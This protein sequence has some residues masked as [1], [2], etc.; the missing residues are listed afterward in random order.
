VLPPL[1]L[2]ALAVAAAA[3][4]SEAPLASEQVPQGDALTEV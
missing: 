2:D 3:A 4:L 1:H